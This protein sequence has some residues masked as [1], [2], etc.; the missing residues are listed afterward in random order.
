MKPAV[1]DPAREAD[2]LAALLSD[3]RDMIAGDPDFALDLAEGETNAF[4]VIDALLAADALDAELC[5]GAKKAIDTIEF[6]VERFGARIKA[7]RAMIERFLL[8]LEQKKLERPSATITLAERGPVCEI[9]D[10]SAVP[11]KFFVATAPKLDKKAVKAALDAGED[12]PGAR[13]SNGSI[14]LTVRRK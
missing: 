13:L 3:Y 11:S 5:D 8:I 12:V 9:E 4:E 14:S 10:E 1:L 6:R 2:A 7:R